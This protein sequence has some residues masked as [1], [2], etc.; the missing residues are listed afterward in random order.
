MT[1]LG[2]DSSTTA[3]Q[4]TNTTKFSM[5]AVIAGLDVTVVGTGAEVD[6]EFYCPAIANS[7]SLL[8]TSWFVVTPG[9]NQSTAQQY[10]NWP[11]STGGTGGSMRLRHLVLDNGVS[12][13]FEVGL[14]A[15][16]ASTTTAHGAVTANGKTAGVMFL[17][18][19]D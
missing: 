5:S 16:G 11:A 6:V 14:S 1:E 7:A 3:F 13:K 2:Y 12:Y 8:M 9:A 15:T 4:T 18:V 10:R 17:R 19:S